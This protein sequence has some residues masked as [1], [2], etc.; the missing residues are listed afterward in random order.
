MS[1]PTHTVSV[2]RHEG[3][4]ADA[5]APHLVILLQADRPLVGSSRHLLDGIDLVRLGRA[6]GDRRRVERHDRELTIG[7]PDARVSNHHARLARL[8]GRWSLIDDGSKNGT[9]LNGA[10]VERAVLGD[11]DLVEVGH[12]FLRFAERGGTAG[13]ADLEAA[14]L[15]P[16][17]ALATWSASLAAGFGALRAVAPSAAPVLLLGPTGT[18]KE[19]AARA[20][21]EL[22][23]RRGA[24]VAVN[25][26]AIPPELVDSELFGHRRGSFSGAIEDRSG[27]FRAA[28]GGTLYL[29]EVSEL[30]PRAQAALLRAL[31]ELEV[32]PVGESRPV[33]VDARVVA[34]TNGELGEG[35]LRSD[36]LARLAGWKLRLPPLAERRED[37]GLLIG[38]LLRRH[39]ARGGASFTAG[40][41]R[42]LLTYEWPANVRELEQAL[43]SALALA[44]G[45]PI[46]LRDL[47]VEVA[48]TSVAMGA[49]TALSAADASLRDELAGQLAAAHGNVSEVARA[50]GKGRMQIH[51]WLRRFGL[52]L[53]RFRK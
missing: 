16:P 26:A 14:E 17:A 10:R 21:H 33:R 2:D 13:P 48:G 11:G 23:R 30:G 19:I 9:L 40:A 5:G 18:G 37:L 46:E 52:D 29:D 53:R 45:R 36:L 24:L 25:C 27:H 3:A 6:R 51:R 42:A 22:S 7:A 34:A 43:R 47:P 15:E 1:K 32:V 31:Q 41:A 50:M 38:T 20:L 44:A 49:A 28:D 39:D 4:A 12:T 35:R 8:H